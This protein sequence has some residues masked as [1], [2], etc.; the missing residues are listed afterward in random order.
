MSRD[1]KTSCTDRQRHAEA[2]VVPFAALSSAVVVTKRDG[3]TTDDRRESIRSLTS[4]VST[5]CC[6]SETDEA[7]YETSSEGLNP[8]KFSGAEIHGTRTKESLCDYFEEK[9]TSLS[10]LDTL[11]RNVSPIKEEVIPDLRRKLMENR[12]TQKTTYARGSLIFESLAKTK[13]LPLI[14]RSA[15]SSSISA[16]FEATNLALMSESSLARERKMS[17]IIDAMAPLIT[18][19]SSTISVTTNN[20]CDKQHE[21]KR[22]ESRTKLPVL[23]DATTTDVIND[24]KSEELVAEVILHEAKNNHRGITNRDPCQD[25]ISTL[26]NDVDVT[27]D[28]DLVDVAR[29][30]YSSIKSIYFPPNPPASL[31][32]SVKSKRR[33]RIATDTKALLKIDYELGPLRYQYSEIIGKTR[34]LGLSS[35]IFDLDVSCRL[36]RPSDNFLNCNETFSRQTAT[37]CGIEDRFGLVDKTTSPSPTFSLVGKPVPRVDFRCASWSNENDPSR[38][39]KALSP[40]ASDSSRTLI[41]NLNNLRFSTRLGSGTSYLPAATDIHAFSPRENAL[42]EHSCNECVSNKFQSLCNPNTVKVERGTFTRGSRSFHRTINVSCSNVLRRRDYDSHH[43]Y[44]ERTVRNSRTSNNNFV[45]V[46]GQEFLLSEKNSADRL[47]RR[48]SSCTTCRSNYTAKSTII[49]MIDNNWCAS[50]SEKTGSE[51]SN[52]RV[53][54]LRADR[55]NSMAIQTQFTTRGGNRRNG[56][57]TETKCVIRD[58]EISSAFGLKL[59]ERSS[60]A[61]L[62]RQISRAVSA[63]STRCAPQIRVVSVNTEF[64]T[65]IEK[66]S[67]AVSPIRDLHSIVPS[68]TLSPIDV[69]LASRLS[70]TFVQQVRDNSSRTKIS[71]VIDSSQNVINCTEI[72]K[73]KCDIGDV[74]SKRDFAVQKVDYHQPV[75]ASFSK[76]FFESVRNKDLMTECEKPRHLRLTEAKEKITIVPIVLTD[77]PT[78][79]PSKIAN[80]NF[81]IPNYVGNATSEMSYQIVPLRMR[82][83]RKTSLASMDNNIE[84][85]RHNNENSAC[86]TERSANEKRY[87]EISVSRANYGGD[88]YTRKDCDPSTTRVVARNPRQLS[89]VANVDRKTRKRCDSAERRTAAR[90]IPGMR[91][92]PDDFLCDT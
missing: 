89:R 20:F 80:V 23:R 73:Y 1:T 86:L 19:D 58:D 43:R 53:E 77:G 4:L 54:G 6:A 82:K 49:E 83:S 18:L 76:T 45:E 56:T 41:E 17:M 27:N 14:L 36:D 33:Q 15:D 30:P 64:H 63:I 87:S 88:L 47:H 55:Q 25:A 52:K 42:N 26:V 11:D 32:D 65:T 8:S 29:N 68:T 74:T 31:D 90:A 92:S 37:S 35:S 59:N 69:L 28:G 51:R 2:S 3:N 22:L 13:S 84:T 62:D 46:R 61:D 71:K 9:S 10:K 57:P 16:N 34:A 44:L 38:R 72:S 21:A 60:V 39:Q 67:R 79:D 7:D 70:R 81:A 78:S 75:A 91:C 24:E 12:L 66:R 48:N 5:V 85:S 50:L 40:T